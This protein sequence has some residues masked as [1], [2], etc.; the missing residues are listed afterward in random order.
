MVLVLQVVDAVHPTSVVAAGGIAD[1]G[2]LVAAVALGACRVWCGTVLTCTYE[3]NIDQAFKDQVL[4]ATERDT[5][6]SR[7]FT[8]KTCRLIDSELI[9]TWEAEQS[10]ILPF[11][12]QMLVTSELLRYMIPSGKTEHLIMA[13]GQIYGMVNEMKSARQVVEETIDKAIHILEET[14]PS[15]ITLNR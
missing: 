6:V 1:G 2:V 12:L 7:V 15:R 4:G 14:F 10:P 8:G 11:P 9:R 13:G 5:R 3:A